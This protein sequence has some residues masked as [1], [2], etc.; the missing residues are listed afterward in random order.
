[1]P[2]RDP[3]MT[4]LLKRLSELVNPVECGTCGVVAQTYGEMRDAGWV[5]RYWRNNN[6][7]DPKANSH[8][9][10]SSGSY[11]SEQCA[12]VAVV[13]KGLLGWTARKAS[14]S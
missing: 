11:C 3:E 1:M 14:E 8:T 7:K 2:D 6:P 12:T 5:W 10:A 13:E 9:S 4:A